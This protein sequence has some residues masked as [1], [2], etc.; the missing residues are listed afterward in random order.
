MAADGD[1]RG[2]RR[3][4]LLGVVVL[5]CAAWLLWSRR[6]GGQVAL[7]NIGT[8]PT[9]TLPPM[10]E[11]TSAPPVVATADPVPDELP[12]AAAPLPDGSAPGPEY[13]IKGNSGSMLFHMPS[14]PYYE[15]TKPALWFRTA[16][17][18]RAA[19]YTEWKPKR[20]ATG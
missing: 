18:A 20:R 10:P 5:A 9:P 12:G 14:S 17:D 16:E 19:G 1:G 7:G 6:T 4:L 2:G 13:T 15:R 3:W 8:V 11:R